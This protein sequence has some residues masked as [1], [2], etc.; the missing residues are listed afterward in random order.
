M[1]QKY[2]QTTFETC[3]SCCLLQAVSQEKITKKNELACINHAMNYSRND[4]VIGHLDFIVKKF[5]VR[6]ERIVDNKHFYSYIKKI[7]TQV[8]KIDLRLID[9]FIK[10]KPILYIDS[11]VLFHVYHYPHFI[12]ML[13]K[14]GSKYKIFDVWDGEIKTIDAKIIAQGISSLRNKIK[15][16]PQMLIVE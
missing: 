4:F 2:K 10:K 3:L 16:C 1:I 13:E 6:I 8:Q 11:I 15:L 14:E 9:R 7:K 12:T 5:N